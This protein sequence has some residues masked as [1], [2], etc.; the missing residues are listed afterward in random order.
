MGL[1]WRM[2]ERRCEMHLDFGG[3]IAYKDG[4]AL[5]G[6][7]SEGEQH[8]QEIEEGEED[9]TDQAADDAVKTSFMVRSARTRCAGM[10]R[11]QLEP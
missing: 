11:K 2:E 6:K 1:G 7:S 3:R 4:D 10:A 9:P 8:G 5:G